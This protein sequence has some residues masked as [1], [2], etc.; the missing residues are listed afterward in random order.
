[1]SVNLHP[2]QGSDAKH[3]PAVTQRANGT[4]GLP[5]VGTKCVHELIGITYSSLTTLG[6]RAVT[7]PF[8]EEETK[9]E[10]GHVTRKATGL[11]HG[12]AGI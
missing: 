5:C 10:R 7:S 6:G 4:Q 8:P 2:P 9:A 12:R 3:G 11:V 1:M